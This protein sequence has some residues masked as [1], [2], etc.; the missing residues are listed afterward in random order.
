MISLKS[1]AE[2]LA[3][4]CDLE[5]VNETVLFFRMATDSDYDLKLVAE[6][7]QL[8]LR[9]ILRPAACEIDMWHMIFR[10]EDYR[11][12]SLMEKH[13]LETLQLVL[14]NDSIILVKKGL[15]FIQFELHVKVEDKVKALHTYGK[16]RWFCNPPAFSGR[17]IEYKGLVKPL[18]A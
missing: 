6:E 12:E 11:E 2:N 18:S 10:E 17:T 13:L 9:A 14:N 16:S 4:S 8:V 7:D 15:L 1:V 5:L 3:G